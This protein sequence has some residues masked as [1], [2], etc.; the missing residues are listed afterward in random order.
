VLV[1]ILAGVLLL[2]AL[3]AALAGWRTKKL[4]SSDT[5]APTDHV[6]VIKGGYSLGRT[7][8]PTEVHHDG[9]GDDP[10]FQPGD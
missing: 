10:D 1:A 3:G 4:Q 9:D 7:V 5:F 8:L 2:M 6:E